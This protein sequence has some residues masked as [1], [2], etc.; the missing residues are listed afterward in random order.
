MQEK[1]DRKRSPH[2][3]SPP[4]ENLPIQKGVT[5]EGSGINPEASEN[6]RTIELATDQSIAARN[7]LY[8]PNQ[9]SLTVMVRCADGINSVMDRLKHTGDANTDLEKDEILISMCTRLMADGGTGRIIGFNNRLAELVEMQKQ[10]PKPDN[11]ATS[12]QA[13]AD[14][15]RANMANITTM[16]KKAGP[17]GALARQGILS[18]MGDLGGIEQHE[19]GFGAAYKGPL[20][21]PGL[22]YKAYASGLCDAQR[23]LSGRS[24]PASVQ[25]V[26]NFEQEF[27]RSRKETSMKGGG[28]SAPAHTAGKKEQRAPVGWSV[29]E[30]HGLLNTGDMAEGRLK[31]ANPEHNK[32]LVDASWP[33][34]L[35]SEQ[36]TRDVVEPVTGHVS[37]TF[38]EMAATM[39]MFCGTPPESVTWETPSGTPI[40]FA[41]KDQVTSIAA[42]SAAGLITAGFHSAVEI[43]QPMS[44]F[45]THATHGSIGPKAVEMMNQH[46]NALRAYANKLDSYEDVKPQEFEH[47]TYKLS[48]EELTLTEEEL[49]NKAQSIEDAATKS[50][51]MISVLQGEGG[52]IATLEVSRVLANHSSDP[53]IP[54]KLYSLNTR[55]DELGLRGHTLELEKARALAALP[56]SKKKQADMKLAIEAAER[57]ADRLDLLHKTAAVAA[58]KASRAEVK[59]EEANAIMALKQEALDSVNKAISD[60]MKIGWGTGVPST[61]AT[62]AR[63]NINPLEVDRRMAFRELTAAK[64]EVTATKLE[65]TAAKREAI[66]ARTEVTTMDSKIVAAA[67]AEAIAS[68]NEAISERKKVKAAN[69]EEK[70]QLTE[71]NA[72]E[73]QNALELATNELEAAAKV[74]A[75]LD[76]LETVRKQAFDEV[77]SAKT[78][79]MSAR[80]EAREAKVASIAAKKESIIT[81]K[82]ALAAR[83]EEITARSHARQEKELRT[84]TKEEPE[85]VMDK[86]KTAKGQFQDLKDYENPEPPKIDM[87]KM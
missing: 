74:G 80:Q 79:A 55:L 63:N 31:E 8:N 43:F 51:D 70:A 83:R 28:L 76:S 65:A 41:S 50:V 24:T 18:F 72:S 11:Y 73:K 64:L 14:D 75:N 52:T 25:E 48:E 32:S 66:A 85:T 39:N 22:I 62:K 5:T 33:S 68:R 82:E 84:T 4:R 10:T 13:L 60:T 38:G 12:V 42:M 81:R 15:C 78:E 71:Q 59:V 20:A 23:K 1:P 46:A 21:K 44:T 35:V 19:T 17:E 69:L 45:T 29:Q 57:A 16:A 2:R 49:K 26:E 53:N 61:E 77:V 47:D 37:G 58:E 67:K 3:K 7:L 30:R 54:S 56:E 6:K 27:N 40:K 87:P 34:Y 9:S 36:V 86:F